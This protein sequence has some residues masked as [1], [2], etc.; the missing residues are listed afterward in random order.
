MSTATT[1]GKKAHFALGTH[2]I[3]CNCFSLFF[4]IKRSLCAANSGRF[5]VVIARYSEQRAFLNFYRPPVYKRSLLAR[6][7]GQET[8]KI[9]LELQ[10]PCPL[11]LPPPPQGRWL[12]E[13]LTIKSYNISIFLFYRC[14]FLTKDVLQ[15]SHLL[16]LKHLVLKCN[17]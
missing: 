11:P 8:A 12:L 4:I 17:R 5:S 14:S 6:I 9:V 15:I 1:R 16:N 2:H 13:Y 10:K 3:F 7:I